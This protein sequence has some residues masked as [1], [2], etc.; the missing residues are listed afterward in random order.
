MYVFYFTDGIHCS[1]LDMSI[2]KRKLGIHFYEVALTIVYVT[3]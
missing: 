3:D 2:S 1:V